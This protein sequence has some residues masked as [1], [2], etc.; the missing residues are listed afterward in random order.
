M[1]PNPSF[2]RSY[3]TPAVVDDVKVASSSTQ[4]QEGIVTRICGFKYGFIQSADLRNIFFH[5]SELTDEAKAFVEEGS[6][7][8]FSETTNQWTADKKPKAI[9]IEVLSTADNNEFK[10]KRGVMQR[11]LGPKG[12]G[13]IFCDNVTYFF[14]ANELVEDDAAIR[15]GN[16]ARAGDEVLFDASWN[17]KYNPPKPCATRVRLQLPAATLSPTSVA[18]RTA[19]E[20]GSNNAPAQRLRRATSLAAP[21]SARGVRTTVISGNG[22]SENDQPPDVIN[23]RAARLKRAAA[24]KRLGSRTV[25]MGVE[26]A[27]LAATEQS[28][29]ETEAKMAA[30]ASCLL[31]GNHHKGASGGANRNCSV[32]SG[33]HN[34]GFQSCDATGI[35]TLRVLVDALLTSGKTQYLVVRNAL[36]QPEYFGRPL[37]QEEK[38]MLTGILNERHDKHINRSSNNRSYKSRRNQRNVE[39]AAGGVRRMNSRGQ[40]LKQN[41]RAEALRQNSGTYKRCDSRMDKP[42]MMTAMAVG[43]AP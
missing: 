36:Q 18:D 34:P 3:S 13:F 12:F 24:P 15:N 28:I 40:Y 20:A 25:S 14:A 2:H 42:P 16:T 31:D 6:K 8:R 17:H 7:V 38:R 4:R 39:A 21:S 26:D 27:A 23:S 10:D 37:T 11:E 30:N 35:S 5:F 19:T 9:N 1:P 41:S 43:Q 29:A 22:S 32:D 33:A